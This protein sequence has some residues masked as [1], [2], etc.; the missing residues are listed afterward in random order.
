M[1]LTESARC[2]ASGTLAT[3]TGLRRY[4]E[5]DA[6]RAR[7][8]AFCAAHEG[9]YDCWQTAW[10]AFV[11]EAGDVPRAEEPAWKRRLRRDAS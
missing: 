3:V 7:F 10:K 6:L 11:Q 9:D 4:D 2:V 5:L 8:V 1:T